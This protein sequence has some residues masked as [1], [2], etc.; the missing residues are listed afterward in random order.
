MEKEED[1]RNSY[2]PPSMCLNWSSYGMS[3]ILLV[4][5]VAF[6]VGVCAQVCRLKKWC[7]CCCLLACFAYE[8][9]R[10]RPVMVG[11]VGEGGKGGKAGEN[12]I[13]TTK[14]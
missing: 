7:A 1:L 3:A 9:D 5:G 13:C 14:E 6:D 10:L 8:R 12:E 2:S 11:G 4:V